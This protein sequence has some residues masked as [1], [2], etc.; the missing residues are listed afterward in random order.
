[1]LDGLNFRTISAHRQKN[2]SSALLQA[3]EFSSIFKYVAEHRSVPANA[4]LE[5]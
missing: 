1:M 3:A 2:A 4:G 5:R